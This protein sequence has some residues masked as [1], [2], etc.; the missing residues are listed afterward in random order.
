MMKSTIISLLISLPLAYLASIP[1]IPSPTKRDTNYLYSKAAWGNAITAW[2]NYPNKTHIEISLKQQQEQLASFT[3]PA[4]K[5]NCPS[6]PDDGSTPV[7]ARHVRPKDIKTIMAIG[8]SITAGFGMTSGPFPNTLLREFRGAVFDIGGDDGQTTIANFLR[9]Y[10]PDLQGESTGYTILKSKID[11]LNAAVSSDVVS[12]LSSQIDN[13]V[14]AYTQGSYDKAEGWNMIGVLIG[15]NNACGMCKDSVSNDPI[16]FENDYRNAMR[17]LYQNFPNSIVNAYT[18]FNVSQVYYAQQESFY[19]KLVHTIISECECLYTA[20]NR[21]MMDEVTSQYNSIIYKVA[22]EF[23]DLPD[24]IINVQPG[25]SDLNL[26]IMGNAASGLNWLSA[27]DCF[28]PNLCANKASA[29]ALWNNMFQSKDEKVLYQ[30]N[31]VNEIYCPGP[32]DFLQ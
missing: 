9:M 27:L 23:Q 11:V 22:S 12:D 16:S 18:L 1:A 32:D 25:I 7:D 19:C 30:F 26:S 3:C 10:N 8:D 6:Y 17:K 28:H 2:K 5:F 29:A 14:T 21:K 15:A 31:N 4:P 24:F 20:D 13:L